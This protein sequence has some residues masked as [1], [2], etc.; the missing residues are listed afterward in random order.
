M[1]FSINRFLLLLVPGWIITITVPFLFLQNCEIILEKA[2]TSFLYTQMG[3]HILFGIKT[4]TRVF[5]NQN[6]RPGF[7]AI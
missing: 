5:S 3:E 2:G 4:K 1:V 7:T 6:I